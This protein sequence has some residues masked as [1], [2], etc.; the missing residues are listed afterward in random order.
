M[1]QTVKEC[2]PFF[3][4]FTD[5]VDEV[6][7]VAVAL[8]EI[9]EDLEYVDNY[10]YPARIDFRWEQGYNKGEYSTTC[11]CITGDVIGNKLL[12][13]SAPKRLDTLPNYYSPYAQTLHVDTRLDVTIEGHYRLT[14]SS[15][16]VLLAA[17]L[18]A[19]HIGACGFGDD[20]RIPGALYELVEYQLETGRHNMYTQTTNP[21]EKLNINEDSQNVL[22]IYQAISS[23]QEH[24]LTIEVDG[25]ISTTTVI[26]YGDVPGA[27][28]EVLRAC[29]TGRLIGDNGY[30][31]GTTS[32]PNT[33]NGN[34][35]EVDSDIVA[36]VVYDLCKL[37]PYLYTLYSDVISSRINLPVYSCTPVLLGGKII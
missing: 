3:T 16:G 26:N 35:F 32:V 33:E 8:I 13:L 20:K 12:H 2:L 4:M 19:L 17:N 6:A 22:D 30:Y 24:Q 34:G 10:H 11:D 15:I 31:H 29:N 36:A 27:I 18:I 28:L 23:V 1:Y 7:E 21:V 5:K 14:V 37:Q 9:Y 25:D